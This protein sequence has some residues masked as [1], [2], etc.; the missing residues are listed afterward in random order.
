MLVP[1]P[2]D[3]GFITSYLE[4]TLVLDVA[5]ASPEP[6]T[7]LHVWPYKSSD[8][9]DQQWTYVNNLYLVGQQSGLVVEIANSDP[10][11]GAAVQINNF[12]FPEAAI[13]ALRDSGNIASTFSELLGVI[14]PELKSVTQVVEAHLEADLAS[15]RAVDKGAGVYLTAT[16]AA[17]EVNATGLRPKWFEG[18]S[19]PRDAG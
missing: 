13:S 7:P 14:P 3:W 12:T 8:N 18:G 6:E 10:G 15:A 17:P 2:I 9:A 11:D 1:A 19:C 16:W 5:G 4:N